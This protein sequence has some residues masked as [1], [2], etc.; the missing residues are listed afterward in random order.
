MPYKLFMID[1]SAFDNTITPE[2]GREASKLYSDPNMR[3]KGLSG[4]VNE[5]YRAD[6]VTLTFAHFRQQRQGL[7]SFDLTNI[8]NRSEPRSRVRS[9]SPC[10]GYWISRSTTAMAWSVSATTR[11]VSTK[12]TVHNQLR[13]I[14]GLRD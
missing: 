10:C 12:G 14:Q 11:I 8:S 4:A 1:T 2:A 6:N 13:V 7:V 3:V 9:D 5:V